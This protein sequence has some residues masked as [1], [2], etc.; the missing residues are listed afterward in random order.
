MFNDHKIQSIG[1]TSFF[2]LFNTEK[3]RKSREF[4]VHNISTAKRYARNIMYILNEYEKNAFIA[5]LC[6]QIREIKTHYFNDV[7]KINTRDANLIYNMTKDLDIYKSYENAICIVNDYYNGNLYDWF[8]NDFVE[9]YNDI[10]K[11]NLNR[12]QIF[13]IIK[14]KLIKVKKKLE[15]IIPKKIAE[16][17]NVHHNN[18]DSGINIL[19]PNVE[20]I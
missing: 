8:I 12:N 1:L 10:N 9:E 17:L 14:N 13:K 16:E 2:D 15:S 11:T 4:N 20:Q 18:I 6:S 3:Y 7:S 5:T 19:N